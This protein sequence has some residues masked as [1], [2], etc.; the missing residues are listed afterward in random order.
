[1]NTHTMHQV[2][3]ASN[4][5]YLDKNHGGYLNIFDRIF[6]SHKHFDE[7]VEVKYGVIH[8]PK[9]NNPLDIVSHEYINIW[10]DVM[11]AKTWKGRW[12]YIWGPPGWSEDGSTMTVKQIHREMAEGKSVEEL[13]GKA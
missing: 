6:G 8:P 4:L 2:H 7:N 11:K 10:K 5:E 3:H 9:T 13:L 1:M 12:M